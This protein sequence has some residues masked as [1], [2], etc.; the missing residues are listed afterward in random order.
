MPAI[1]D[2]SGYNGHIKSLKNSLTKDDHRTLLCK[3]SMAFVKHHYIYPRDP[4]ISIY[5]QLFQTVD[6]FD[7]IKVDD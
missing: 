4:R 2:P 3:A 6:I 5:I 1:K 7:L